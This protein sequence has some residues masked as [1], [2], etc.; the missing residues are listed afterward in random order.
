MEKSVTFAPSNNKFYV[1]SLDKTGVDF[2]KDSGYEPIAKLNPSKDLGD[3]RIEPIAHEI[4]R[5]A[6]RDFRAGNIDSVSLSNI[7]VVDL[8]Q[9]VIRR[10][11]RQFNAINGVTRV[12]V[13]K[14]QLKVPIAEKYAA[15]KKVPELVAADQKSNDFTTVQ[16]DLFKN[17]VNILESDESQMKGTIQPLNFE[18]DQAAGA[19]GEAANEQIV[20]EIRTIGTQTGTNWETVTSGHSANSPLKDI[21]TAMNT[22]VGNHFRPNTV[23]LGARGST[24]YTS[25]DFVRGHNPPGNQTIEG[26]FPLPHYPGVTG[27]VD[28]GFTS[29]EAI[30][31]DK[32]GMLLGEGPT[33]AESFRDPQSGADGY[34]IRQWMEPKLTTADIGKRITGIHA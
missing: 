22:I 1:G 9:E 16:F 34:V 3:G 8:L 21:T 14:L 19:L 15:S 18:I 28:F 13:P 12:P 11:W 2:S 33:V 20:T 32:A 24:A 23:A 30:V 7:T 10:Q 27:I 31:Y 4:Y 6:E 25:N 5:Q 17:V 26:M 29:T